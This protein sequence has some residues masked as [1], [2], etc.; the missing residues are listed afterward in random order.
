MLMNEEFGGKK[1][2]GEEKLSGG[3]DK[4]IAVTLLCAPKLEP[5]VFVVAAR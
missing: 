4:Y 5:L 2:E 3:D 1:R